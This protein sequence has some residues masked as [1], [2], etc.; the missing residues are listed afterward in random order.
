MPKFIVDLN[1]DGYESEEEHVE[2]CKQFIEEQLDF[3]ANYITVTLLE[4][5]DE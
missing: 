1:L 5:A 4:D 2:A 3:S